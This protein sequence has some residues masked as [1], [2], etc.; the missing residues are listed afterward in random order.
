MALLPAYRSWGQSYIPLYISTQTG[1]YTSFSGS[2]ERSSGKYEEA[3]AN[4]SVKGPIKFSVD[5][6]NF[7]IGH[8]ETKQW[9]GKIYPD[10]KNAP[11]AGNADTAA[12]MATYNIDYIKGRVLSLANGQEKK[13]GVEVVSKGIA[14]ANFI[15]YSVNVKLSSNTYSICGRGNTIKA[16]GYP[17]GGEYTWKSLTGAV[18]LSPSGTAGNVNIVF[19]YNNIGT[20]D[21][22]T[23]VVKYSISGVNYSDTCFINL[24]TEI[25]DVQP[26]GGNRVPRP[27]YTPRGGYHSPIPE[28]IASAYHFTPC[29]TSQDSCYGDC[30]SYRNKCDST[31]LSC[32]LTQCRNEP[33]D[34]LRRKC[35]QLSAAM[36]KTVDEWGYRRYQMA[37][38]EACVNC[39]K[40]DAKENKK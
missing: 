40:E 1:E 20:T 21:K 5:P 6:G 18:K 2:A 35:T 10:A 4:L 23:V 34:S 17:A 37:Q 22:D 26:A 8:D 38:K 30:R 7:T 16:T 29:I 39:K 31:L 14:V 19:D 24:P 9:H 12:L 11:K 28:N 25:S 32:M 13:P 15:V 36:Y 27:G 3:K 33:N